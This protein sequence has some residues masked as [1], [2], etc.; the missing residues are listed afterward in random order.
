ML[1]LM[2]LMVHEK[3]MGAE[4]KRYQI[5]QVWRWSGDELVEDRPYLAELADR[6]S[7]GLTATEVLLLGSSAYAAGDRMS[8][9]ARTERW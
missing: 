4:T 3:A 7:T 8:L 9:R 2:Y 5:R 1:W 6:V